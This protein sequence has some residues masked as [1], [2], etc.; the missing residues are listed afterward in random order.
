MSCPACSTRAFASPQA[1]S[2]PGE[3]S[4]GG[5]EPGNSLCPFRIQLR[6]DGKNP[7]IRPPEIGLGRAQIRQEPMHP[8]LGA[9]L[10]QRGHDVILSTTTDSFGPHD[11]GTAH[12]MRSGR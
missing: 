2:A 8:G 7:R 9:I 12:I 5:T 1:G 10:H 3:Q 4:R 6:D 11:G